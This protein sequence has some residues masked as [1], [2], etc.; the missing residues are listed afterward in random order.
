MLS[1]FFL[2]ILKIFFPSTTEAWAIPAAWIITVLME[3]ESKD[4]KVAQHYKLRGA[5]AMEDQ[6]LEGMPEFAKF[7]NGQRMRAGL[8]DGYIPSCGDGGNPAITSECNGAGPMERRSVIVDDAVIMTVADAIMDR[9][10]SAPQLE[11]CVNTLK[12]T[13][14]TMSAMVQNAPEK[15]REIKEGFSVIH[16]AVSDSLDSE[17]ELERKKVSTEHEKQRISS[18]GAMELEEQKRKDVI[19]LDQKKAEGAEAA[20]MRAEKKKLTDELEYDV[21]VIRC[22][23]V[24]ARTE[25][26]AKLAEGKNVRPSTYK[27][28]IDAFKKELEVTERALQNAKRV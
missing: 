24:N 9:F 5:H 8:L 17:L 13:F 15:A 11:Q 22:R 28:K 23:I 27:K 14:D 26:L 10:N 16:L 2:R 4:N 19:K 18:V 20:K 21:A 7:W 3:P 12:R 6:L 25:H 1:Y